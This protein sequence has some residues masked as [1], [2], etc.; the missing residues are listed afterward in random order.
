MADR[1]H[2]LTSGPI[3]RTL[4]LFSLPILGSNVLQ[5][6]NVSVNSIWIGHYLGEAALTA[7]SNANLV[8]FFLL[9]TVFGI[10]MAGTILVGQAM[11]R[12]DIDQAKRV[13]GTGAAFFVGLSAFMAILG[14]VFTPEILALM[15]T[16]ADAVPYAIAYLRVI[17]VALP[18]MFFYS[19]LMM[20]LRGA[21]DSHTPFYFMLLSV[22]LD[23]TLNPLLIFGIGPLPALGIAGSAAATLV[24]QIIAL[25]A[26]LTYL[27]GRKHFLCLHRAEWHYL[28]PDLALLRVLVLKGLPMGIQ[29]IVLSSSGLI[30]IG[31]INAYGSQVTAAY[32]AALQLWRYIQMPALAVGSA[33]ASMAA[34]NV[35]AGKWHRVSRVAGTG[36]IYNLLLT[37]TLVLVVYFFSRHA[38]GLFLPNDSEALNIAEHLNHIAVWAFLLIS[39]SFVLFGVIRSTG[40]MVPP[41]VILVIALFGVRIPFAWV[42]RAHFGADAVWWSYPIGSAATLVLS[43]AYYRFGRWR[44][45]HMLKPVRGQ[46][47]TTG[48]STPVV[49][50]GDHTDK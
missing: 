35:G 29:M 47:N 43:V 33:V 24:A 46:G 45:A 17:F 39:V 38:L 41:L 11:G 8:L 3:A 19:F 44:H 14:F 30:M 32:G 9:G 1:R 49:A 37:G 12:H 40:A 21:G 20:T 15:Q 18:A 48:M 13:I 26:L 31:L 22:G 50:V 25:C 34:Q 6:L 10:S 16:P 4:V 42:L 5:S 23:I 7:S 28:K 36:V 2:H 27:Y